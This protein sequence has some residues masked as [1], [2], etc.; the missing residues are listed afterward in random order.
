MEKSI[1]IVCLVWLGKVS[2]SFGQDIP[3]RQV[4]SVV[5]NKFYQS[6]PDASDPEWGQKGALYKVEFEVGLF[7]TDHD[8]WYDKTGKLIA[9]K[10]EISKR[11]LP[12]K[13]LDT[14]KKGFGSYRID[15]SE[16]IAKGHR[17]I[18]TVEL[19]NSVEELK[20]TFDVNGNV[21]SKI[22]D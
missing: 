7:S 9:H 8:A 10:E 20:V 6:F 16:K 21:L 3:T 13:I 5:V 1:L 22:A 19:K 18:Y 2:V 15:D 4:P 17:I 11:N 14:I 12:A